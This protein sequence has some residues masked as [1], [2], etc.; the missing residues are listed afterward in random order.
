V[1]ARRSFAQS[2]QLDP[3][4][5]RTMGFLASAEM[6]EGAIEHDER[7]TRQGYF[8]MLDAITMWPA[9]NKF[10]GGYVLSTA[11]VAS[12]QF[13][14]ALDWQWDNIDICI[15]AKIDRAHPDFTKYTAQVKDTRAC[16]DTWKAPHNAE[17]FFLN[18]GDMLVRA[19]DW[20]RAQLIYA[21]AKL[22]PGWRTWPYAALLEERIRSAHAN[23][24]R[25]RDSEHD[26]D[27]RT[28]YMNTSALS[29][30]G[31]HQDESLA[32]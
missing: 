19:G 7:L 8:R 11:P 1:L 18:M 9:F 6:G 25:F 13:R 31:C 22:F 32:R 29:C 14:Q 28:G 4:D 24:A 23:V 15:G 10:T 12:S 16:L 30:M 2:V 17:G 21:D 26:P 3:H 27:P 5:A 20:Q